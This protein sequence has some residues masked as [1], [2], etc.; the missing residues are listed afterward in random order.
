MKR[1][2]FFAAVAI[3]FWST[4]AT[5]VKL[6]LGSLSSMQVLCISSFFAF[7]ALLVLNLITGNIKQL[8]G[9]R[10]RDY[11]I[12]V[13]IGLPGTFIYY[14]FFYSGTARLPAS[15]SMIINYLWPIMS[16]GKRYGNF[17]KN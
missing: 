11:L 14:I 13:A 12:T 16:Y 9:Y 4:V 15:Q 8:K 5:V 3:L 17:L 1:S 7:F 10:V 2:Y 6:L